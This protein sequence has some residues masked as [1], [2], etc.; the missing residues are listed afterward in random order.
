MQDLSAPERP[1]VRPPQRL[2]GDGRAR[3]R[4]ELHLDRLAS[5]VDVD[6]R[7]DIALLQTES[8]EIMRQH[9]GFEF[10]NHRFRGGSHPKD[11][12]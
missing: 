11:T 2:N 12:L 1:Y 3:S 6:H 9:Y 8:W 5:F 10:S 4:N 7:A